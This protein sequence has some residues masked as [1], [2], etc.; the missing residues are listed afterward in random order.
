MDLKILAAVLT[1]L[2]AVF[3]AMNTGSLQ[4]PDTGQGLSLELPDLFSSEPPQANTPVTSQIKILQQNT[5]MTVNGDITVQSLNEYNSNGVNIV[6]ENDIEFQGFNGELIIAK[7]N[8]NNSQIAGD[9]TGYESSGVQA[10][11]NFRLEKHLNTSRIDIKNAEK[12]SLNFQKADIDLQDTN[13]SSGITEE[14]TTV[15][16]QSFTGNITAY[17]E[18]MTLDLQGNISKVEAGQTTF[19]N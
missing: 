17:P 15:N 5:T 19:G 10:S 8:Q 13:S 18:N 11:R 14:N 12:V 6:S 9:V 4:T 16:I 7:G 2:A 3:V 1:T